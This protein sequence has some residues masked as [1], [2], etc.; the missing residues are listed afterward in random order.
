MLQPISATPM[1]PT[2]AQMPPVQNWAVLVE[3][4]NQA[5]GVIEAQSTKEKIKIVLNLISELSKDISAS[6]ISPA[7]A[8]SNFNEIMFLAGCYN[9]NGYPVVKSALNSLKDAFLS[10]M[11]VMPKAAA[12]SVFNLAQ[13][14]MVV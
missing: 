14:N 7:K 1:K 4:A 11:Y 13:V 10:K 5:M 6:S 2:Y 8:K 3:N 12:G 9:V